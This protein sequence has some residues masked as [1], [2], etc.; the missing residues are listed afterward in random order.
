MFVATHAHRV[1]IQA[2]KLLKPDGIF[3][4]V[5][6]GGDSLHELRNSFAL[7]EQ[8]RDGETACPRELRLPGQ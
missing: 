7:A 2:Q 1:M 5:M 4:A 6:L 8:E 3:L